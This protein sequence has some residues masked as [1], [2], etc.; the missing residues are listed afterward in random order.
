MVADTDAPGVK[1]R[2]TADR[3]TPAPF[4]TSSNVTVII[5]DL[6]EIYFKR[7]NF[8]DYV[9][10]KPALQPVAKVENLCFFAHQDFF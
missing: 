9:Q 8:R 10:N 5:E 4:A 6:S 3:D 1:V 7:S 2:D